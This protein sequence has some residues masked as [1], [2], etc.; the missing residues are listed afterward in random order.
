M[1][2]KYSRPCCMIPCRKLFILGIRALY[3][4]LSTINGVNDL[5]N[6]PRWTSSAWK[7]QHFIVEFWARAGSVLM[8]TKNVFQNPFFVWF[9]S[10]LNEVTVMLLTT[11]LNCYVGD[12][13][14]NRSRTSQNCYQ[15]RCCPEWFW[16]NPWR[17]WKR[18]FRSLSILI[19]YNQSWGWKPGVRNEV[20]IA[21]VLK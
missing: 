17:S 15:H 10:Q 13:F 8:P 4:V 7:S 14:K 18:P 12:F 3:G 6:S 2:G 20:P 11:F 9:F 1:K 21:N 16:N 19:A 5:L